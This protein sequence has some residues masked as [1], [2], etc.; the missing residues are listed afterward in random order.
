MDNTPKDCI[1]TKSIYGRNLTPLPIIQAVKEVF[2]SI[3]LDPC[4]DELANK[5]ID[6]QT[7]YTLEEDGFD[8]DWIA[9]TVWMNPPGKSI[10][11]RKKIFSVDWYRKLYDHWCD[12]DINHCITLVYGAGRIG[13]LGQKMLQSSKICL[14]ASGISTHSC[15]NSSG[16]INFDLVENNKRIS[17]KGNTQSSAILLLSHDLRVHKLF[18]NFFAQFG[19]ILN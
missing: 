8:K 17:T 4:S 19:A 13:G 16:R 11:N 18:E 2:N 5:Q 6:A 9:N 12:E 7:F 10:S 15:V 14:T 3:D 1:N